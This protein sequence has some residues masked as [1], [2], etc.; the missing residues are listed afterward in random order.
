MIREIFLLICFLIPEACGIRNSIDFLP[1]KFIG[2]GYEATIKKRGVLKSENFGQ[3]SY[4]VII[5]LKITNSSNNNLIFRIST[6]KFF[7]PEGRRIALYRN[8]PAHVFD[9]DISVT[10]QK[11]TDLE[12]YLVVYDLNENI[13][14]KGIK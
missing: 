6:I 5:N 3:I 14:F 8:I 12:L 13:Q 9:Q 4:A 7:D 2:N 10:P 1:T 11:T